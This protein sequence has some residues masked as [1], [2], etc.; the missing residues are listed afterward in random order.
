MGATFT[1]FT[2]LSQTGDVVE[3][4]TVGDWEIGDPAAARGAVEEFLESVPGHQGAMQILDETPPP[5]SDD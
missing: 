1:K 4:G 3:P 2:N 5:K